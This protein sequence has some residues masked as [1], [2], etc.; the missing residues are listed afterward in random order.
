M[1]CFSTYSGASM[2]LTNNP[3][4][5]SYIN[6]YAINTA[7]DLSGLDITDLS[8]T[9]SYHISAAGINTTNNQNQNT[10]FALLNYN[11]RD[12]TVSDFTGFGSYTIVLKHTA[13]QSSLYPFNF[14]YPNVINLSSMYASIDQDFSA[15]FFSSLSPG[16]I[17]PYSISGFISSDLSGAP[18]SGTFTAPY[19]VITY[20]VTAAPTSSVFF[21]VS[22][23]LSTAFY[24]S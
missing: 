7:L 18:V 24:A 22:G 3:N 14:L 15:Q 12:L 10:S 8:S 6:R 21:N 23:G 20:R 4:S 17:I 5:L 19:T 2:R 11:D 9:T 1:N 13:S 16:T